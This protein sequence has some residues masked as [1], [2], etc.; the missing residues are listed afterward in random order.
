M[1]EGLFVQ[2]LSFAYGPN[3][4]LDGVSFDLQKG[5]FCALL[6]PNGAGKSTLVS[7]LTRL[8]VSPLA[9]SALPGM[10]CAK[11]PVGRW[12]SWAWFF[13]SQRWIWI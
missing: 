12:P 3:Q 13:N 6:G 10:T 9:R 7:L 1:T 8:L 5:R 4:A 11:R 2:D